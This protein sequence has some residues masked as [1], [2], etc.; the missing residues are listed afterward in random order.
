MPRVPS[1]VVVVAVF[2][3][4][5]CAGGAAARGP[6]RSFELLTG[7]A[8]ETD[9]LPLIVALHGRGST[10]QRF[11]RVFQGFAVPARVAFLEAPIPEDHGRAWFTFGLF[12]DPP[13]AIRALLPRIE[14][15]VA[16]LAAA[17]PTR[18]KPVV[19]GFS[20]GAMLI[21]PF[22]ALH[23]ATFC[24]AVP[25]AGAAWPELIP[26][27]LDGA[28]LPPIRAL[29]GDADEVIPASAESQTIETFRARGSD[30]TLEIVPGAHHWIGGALRAR[31]QAELAAMIATE[32][33]A[34]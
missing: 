11:Q 12:A 33:R 23:P 2:L 15:T 17:H 10:P 24:G 13:A 34:P 18:G 25:V 8:H 31:F 29:H 30:A 16:A 21:Y 3:L 22:L 20:Q 27:R 28:R 19:T 7:G 32:G 1:V 14:A 26:A 6:L 4:A 5:G 9:T